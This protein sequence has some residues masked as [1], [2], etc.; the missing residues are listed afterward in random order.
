MRMIVLLECNISGNLRIIFSFIF[1]PGECKKPET[2]I[3]AISQIIFLQ[4]F[5]R[6]RRWNRYRRCHFYGS[7]WTEKW[8]CKSV[9]C[10]WLQWGTHEFNPWHVDVSSQQPFT[11]EGTRP[12]PERGK[13]TWRLAPTRP[14]A[15]KQVITF[16]KDIQ[17][18]VKVNWSR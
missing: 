18:H 2:H 3:V 5:G 6:W 9:R 12:F 13:D 16:K 14:G 15:T 11:S 10:I 1:L 4:D 17:R 7:L 8:N